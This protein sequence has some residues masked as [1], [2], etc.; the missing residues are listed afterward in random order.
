MPQ[1]ELFLANLK[2]WSLIYPKEAENLSSTVCHRV[3]F[4]TTAQGEP[5]LKQE[6]D[7]TTH[8]YHSQDN[9]QAEAK[10]WFSSLD[11]RQMDHLFVFGVGLGYY[12]EAAKEWLQNPSHY[13]IFLENDLEVIHSLFET[14]IGTRILHDP[15]VRLQYFDSQEVSNFNVTDLTEGVWQSLSVLFSEGAF[16]VSALAHYANAFSDLYQIINTTLSF[17]MMLNSGFVAEYDSY[18]EHFFSN[19]YRNIFI[20]PKA[21]RANGLFE[22]F[23]G[24]PAII[25]GAGPSLDK[26]LAVLETLGDKALIFAGGTAMNAVNSRGFQPHFGLGVDP[27]EAQMSRL[28]MNTAYEV[29]FLYRNRVYHEA[30]EFWQGNK[31]YLT[32]TGGYITSEWFEK[33]LA[34]EGKIIPEG[35]NVVNLSLSIAHSLGCNPIIFVGLDLAYTDRHSYQSGVLCHPTHLWKRDFKTKGKHDEL[36]TKNDIYGNPVH[37]LWKWVTESMWYSE[38]AHANPETIFINATEGGIGMSGI[39]NAS[40]QEVA[41]QFCKRQLDLRLWTH[42]EIQNS[43]MPSTVTEEK[44]NQ[45][46]DTLSESLQRCQEYSQRIIEDSL[47]NSSV[48]LLS[49]EGKSSLNK[50]SDEIAY[51]HL[52]RHFKD[53]FTRKSSLEL[54]QIILDSTLTPEGM[55]AK[56]ARLQAD[57]YRFVR[58]T[59]I[60]NRTLIRLC[61]EQRPS[62]VLEN[63]K[64]PLSLSLDP[65]DRYSFENH[66]LTLI[67]PSLGLNY[68]EQ[69]P[70]NITP[71]PLYY[72]DGSI[73][74]E[75]FYLDDLL[76]GPVTFYNPQGHLLAKCWYVKGIKQGKTWL[77]YDE[78]TLYSLQRYVNGQMHGKQEYYYRSGRQKTTLNYCEGR[79]DGFNFLYYPNGQVK[80]EL[81]FLQGKRHGIEKMWDEAGNL[82]IEVEYDQDRPKGK[83]KKWHANGRLAE[84]ISYD[85]TFQPLSMKRWNANGVEETISSEDY[86]DTVTKQTELLTKSLDTVY[87]S[88]SHLELASNKE[89][90]NTFQEDL[91]ELKHQFDYLHKM[92]TEMLLESGLEGDNIQELIWKTPA[93]QN[94][95]K[96]QLEEITKK[97]SQDITHI[98]DIIEQTVDELGKQ[99]KES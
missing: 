46:L 63:E 65:Q 83:A 87:D 78:K 88:L 19:F 29:P 18:G 12:Y 17:W 47:N 52:L 49:E 32:G 94:I 67:D 26:N 54:Q 40:L 43:T 71:S 77:N 6:I 16:K 14:E 75:Q 36:L 92:N 70:L 31:L 22:K 7:G 68:Q 39:P 76:H 28:I 35:A 25:C 55:N 96:N 15:R 73:K 61:R 66:V 50:L 59:A 60:V 8:Y 95:I 30:L 9:P 51:I 72:E 11:T 4:C 53:H 20:L 2:R 27:N 62:A 13:L 57:C 85:A 80:R 89:I 84:E 33:Q 24:V 90:Q 45:L 58:D 3:S 41:Q 81:H 10:Q 48:D 74:L 38:Y 82:M 98:Q 1:S 44:I 99:N 79:L 93:S 91:A 5:N 97:M 86:F 37:T 21:Y 56:K 69:Q 34:I 64:I 23:S 42:G